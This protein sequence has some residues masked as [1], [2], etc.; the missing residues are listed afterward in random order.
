MEAALDIHTG[1]L[2]SF[3]R[4]ISVDELARALH[5]KLA[6]DVVC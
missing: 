4:V 3:E 1:M 5:A 2:T 6:G